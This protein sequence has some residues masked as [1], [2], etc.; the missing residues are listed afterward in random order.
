MNETPKPLADSTHDSP[1]GKWLRRGF[2]LAIILGCAVAM[3]PNRADPDLWG[4]VRYGEDVLRDGAIA[5]TTTYSFTA[6]GYR[7]I[8]HENLAE[9]LLAVGANCIGPIGLLLAKCALGLLVIL[10]IIRHAQRGGAGLI[11]VGAVALLVAVNLAYHWSIRPQ[12][13]TYTYF[14]LLIALLAYCFHGWEGQWHLPTRG[15]RSNA[16]ER[17]SLEYDSQ[18]L[19]F[20]WLAPVIFLFWANSHGGFV[21]GFCIF[22]VYLICRSIEALCRRGRRAFGLVQRFAMMIVAAGLATLVNPYG[23]GLHL[24]LI[25]SLGVPRPEI[26]EWQAP[27][28]WTLGAIP[29]WLMIGFTLASLALSRRSRDFTHLVLLAL[30]LWQSLEHIRHIPFFAILFGFWMPLH[31]ASLL[32]RLGVSREG[33]EFSDEMSPTMRWVV[34]GGL[35]AAFVL[36]GGKL[37]SRLSELRVERSYFPVSAVQYIADQNLSG[38]LVVTYNWA[39]Y[40]IGVFGPKQA[41]DEGILVGF[42]GRFRTCYPQEVVDMHFDLVIGQGGPDVRF[43]SPNSPPFD[44]SRVL[45]FKQPDLVLVSRYQKP[46]AAFMQTQTARWSLLYQDELAQLWGRRSIYDDPRNSSFIPPSERVIGDELQTGAVAWPAF[47]VPRQLNERV[48]AN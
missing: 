17:P 32:R 35:V 24:W 26:T 33:N 45:E 20:L 40:V 9:I 5:E 6:N 23:P 43:R 7:W 39:Q 18:R 46:S 30:T 29:L 44:P 27:E 25:Q 3:S 28:L 42:D 1:A 2:L 36:L 31:V 19:R 13:L 21:A 11:V 12:L 4:H 15:E 48:V 14:T 37:Y 8:N 38:R 47:P 16:D 41:G 22:A 10:L 34:S